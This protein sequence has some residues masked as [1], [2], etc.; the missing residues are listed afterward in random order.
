MNQEWLDWTRQNLDRGCDP[1]EIRSILK[2]NGFSSSDIEKA[3]AQ[4]K[5]GFIARV[6]QGFQ[7]KLADAK[8]EVDRRQSDDATSRIA[9]PDL[10]YARMAQPNLLSN[11]ALKPMADERIQLYVLDNFFSKKECNEVIAEINRNLRPSTITSGKDYSGFRTSST[12]D[13]GHS[14]S[15]LAAKVDKKIARALGIRLEWSEVIQ[16]Q[17]YEVGQ[18]FKAHTDYF[19]PNSD[20]FKNFA[21]DLGQRTWTFMVY[22]NDTPQGGETYFTALDLKF[23]PKAGQAVI[24]NNLYENGEPNPDTIHHG[25]PVKE[26]NKIIITKWFRDKGKG[27]PFFARKK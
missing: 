23:T 8:A 27:Q 15:K 17:K 6:K 10:D 16:G 2:K 11:P 22:L 21:A 19:E 7:K 20:E 12:C 24:W 25:M 9:Q 14:T 4:P 26:G 3:M 1:N 5:L 18:E 13:L